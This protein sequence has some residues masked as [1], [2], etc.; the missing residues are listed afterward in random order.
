MGGLHR[1][2]KDVYVLVHVE[3]LNLSG[4]ILKGLHRLDNVLA[5]HGVDDILGECRVKVGLLQVIHVAFIVLEILEGFEFFA[6]G[7]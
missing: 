7:F 4:H 6:V 5:R 2:R 1:K 3:P